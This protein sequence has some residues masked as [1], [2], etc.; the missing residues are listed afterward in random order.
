MNTGLDVHHQ[1]ARSLLRQHDT[2]AHDDGPVRTLVRNHSRAKRIAAAGWRA[3][4]AIVSFTAASAGRSVGAVDPA[5]TSQTGS[6]C[7]VLVP[8]GGAVRWQSGPECGTSRHRDHTAASNIHWRGQ[9]RGGLAGRP[10]RMNR[11]PAGL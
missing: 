9:R 8:T 7:G 6:G 5:C 10:A 1:T 2:I 3:L 11:E 4:L